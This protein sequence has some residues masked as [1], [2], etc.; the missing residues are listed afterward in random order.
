MLTRRFT[1][2]CAAVVL[3]LAIAAGPVVAGD[4]PPTPPGKDGGSPGN[5]GNAP[6]QN[7]DNGNGQGNGQDNGQTGTIGTGAQGSVSAKQMAK[8]TWDMRGE[9]IAAALLANG[10][11]AVPF[12]ASAEVH[13]VDLWLTPSLARYL[14]VLTE[15]FEVLSPGETYLVEIG[16]KGDRPAST[17]GGTLHVVPSEQSAD[18]LRRTYPSPLP[19]NVKFGAG[20]GS[21]PPVNPTIA[22]VNSATFSG[23]AVAPLQI[24]SIFG[25][26]IGPADFSP[27]IIEDGKV[28]DYLADVQVFFDG[29]AAPIIFASATQ[30]NVVVPS[31]VAGKAEVTLTVAYRGTTWEIT[32]IPVVD[33]MPGIFAMNG[34]GHGLAAAVDSNGQL[35]SKDNPVTPG[36]WITFFG[37]G[38][39]LWK[40]G[41]VDGTVVDPASL[42]VPKKPVEVKIG[43]VI[44]EVL[45]I[46]GA[47]GMVS[48]VVQFNVVVPD[49]EDMSEIDD[50]TDS[51]RAR[52]VLT[53]AGHPSKAEIYI[54]VDLSDTDE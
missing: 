30:L 45:Y 6:G 15:P 50:S 18:G 46:G 26:G 8:I 39:G 2:T 14:E 51:P 13:D 22:V 52:I 38:V 42:P 21:E 49:E 27:P 16:L 29:T 11:V 53:S 40:D 19:I 1:A 24:V 47:P 7:K 12:Q 3:G 9:E 5:S 4:R 20:G 33:A 17:I 32:G 36:E 25:F 10:T 41:F 34:L 48:G 31:D 44:A 54:Y 37:T 35:I 23:D 28:T 43:G